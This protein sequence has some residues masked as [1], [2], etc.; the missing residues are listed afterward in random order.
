M[1][2]A[3]ALRRASEPGSAPKVKPARKARWRF[4]KN[5]GV[6]DAIRFWDGTTFK[7]RPIRRNDGGGYLPGS[8]VDTDDENLARRLRAAASNPALGLVEVMI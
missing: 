5:F 4:V 2:V 1:T 6:A 3:V 7:F 8:Q